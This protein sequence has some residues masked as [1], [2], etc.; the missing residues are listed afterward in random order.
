MNQEEKI[1]FMQKKK[2]RLLIAVL[3]VIGAFALVGIV[4]F[5]ATII[6]TGIGDELLRESPEGS[7]EIRYIFP[8]TDWDRNVFEESV[9]MSRY[10]EIQY[11][12]GVATTVITEEN[13]EF[14]P[15]AVQ[16][17]Y[18]VVWLIINGDYEKYN[19]IFADEYWENGGK[20]YEF[21]MQALYNI[22]IQII[23]ESDDKTSA[24]VSLS[25][26]MYKNDGMF[27]SDLPY[28][29]EALR[30]FVYRLIMDD[31][32]KIKV[33]DKFP[34]TIIAGSNFE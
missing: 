23:D 28:D 22:E 6:S 9:Y 12:D 25:Y 17:M 21:P 11:N 7:D 18:D 5:I 16:F 30:P 32:G 29:E 13:K 24:D 27:R 10:R 1:L 19:E 3:V 4:L 26:M 34:Q 15:P 33:L 14:R 2:K 8:D 31:E 20:D